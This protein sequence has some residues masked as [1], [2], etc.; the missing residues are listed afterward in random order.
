MHCNYWTTR[1]AAT[2]ERLNEIY[3]CNDLKRGNDYCSSII[4]VRGKLM[5]FYTFIFSFIEL[6]DRQFMYPLNN[7]DTMNWYSYLYYT[8][9]HSSRK[10]TVR[11]SS[12]LGGGVSAFVGGRGVC[13]AGGGGVRLAW[14]GSARQGEG[15]LPGGCTPALPLPPRTD[16]DLWKHNLPATTVEDG[17]YYT[18]TFEGSL[19]L[20]P[21]CLS[22]PNGLC[23]KHIINYQLR[24]TSLQVN[25]VGQKFQ[26]ACVV[27]E[28]FH[29]HNVVTRIELFLMTFIYWLLV[30]RW[31]LP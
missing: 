18:V 15:C 9:M 12:H 2:K 10:R 16:R 20:Y 26:L 5:I 14:G 1:N 13:L 23:N 29:A 6:S 31:E 19:V 3:H 8:R 30:D 24:E 25:Y 28:Y 11:C 17:N 7:Q 27:N 21:H 4:L 22:R